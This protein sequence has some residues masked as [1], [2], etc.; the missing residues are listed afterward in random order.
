[1]Y[2][3]RFFFVTCDLSNKIGKNSYS[4]PLDEMIW[5]FRRS[6]VDRY[7][8]INENTESNTAENDRF[9]FL[10]NFYY[11]QIKMDIVTILFP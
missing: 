6:I 3:C 7:Y 8:L 5:Y 11:Q 10:G 2:C 9:A 4:I 1:M